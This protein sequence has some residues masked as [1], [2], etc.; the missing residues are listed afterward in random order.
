[1][2]IETKPPALYSYDA[3]VEDR[4]QRIMKANDSRSL[5]QGI[6]W[7]GKYR[8]TKTT[9]RPPEEAF[10]DHMERLLNPSVNEPIDPTLANTT[11]T[12]IPLLDDPFEPEELLKVVDN[13]V[14]PD[15]GCG[16]DGNSPGTLKLLPIAWLSLLLLIMNNIFLSGM[17]PASWA[18]SKLIMIFKK[19]AVM[20]C[21]NYRGISIIVCAAKCYDYLLN[22]RLIQWY[23]PCRE[24]AGAQER[25]GCIEHI[26]S[27]RL[28]IERCMRLR[29]PL[30]IAFIDFSKAYDRVPR[31]YL[32]N[33]L[34]RLGCGKVML[35][36]LIAM[37]SVTKF[38]LGT[39]LIAAALGVKQ[40]SPTSC[41]LFILYVDELIKTIKKTHVTDGFLGWLQLLMLM[42]DTIIIATSHD[43]LR[44]KLETMIEWCNKSG[45]VIN[46]DKTEFMAFNAPPEGKRPI[47]LKTH[48]GIVNVT[49]CSQ[50]TYLGSIFTSDGKVSSAIDKHADTRINAL[51]KLVRFLD[52]NE[53]APFLVKK[54]VVDACF[55][56]SLLYGCESWLGIKPSRRIKTMY[57]K[58]IRMLLGVRQQ[59]SEDVCLIE[60]GYP[61]LEALVRSRQQS[62]IKKQLQE[63]DGMLDDPLM[64]A[65]SITH[66]DNPVLS[67]YIKSLLDGPDDIIQADLQQRKERMR[68]SGKTKIQTYCAINP[69][70]SV[71][72]MYKNPVG[73]R[74]YLRISFTRFRTSSHS[75]K[76]E[77][78][79]WSRIPRDQRT[80]VCN[81]GVQ[82][83]EHVLTACPSVNDIKLKYHLNIANFVEFMN[84]ERSK[85]DLCAVHE[86]M[87]RLES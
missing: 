37:Y 4:W 21:G 79:R 43:K 50:Y 2:E 17:Y 54:C 28:I 16:H 62:F 6:D 23:V 77:T 39:T 31:S 3:K 66:R 26:V 5:W 47:R 14:K 63:R 25:R 7:N 45:M 40:G 75:L 61:S 42:D 67:R 85:G 29:C 57:M 76:I 72:P 30:Y 64:H 19:G 52:I 83:E 34:K 78:G 84:S 35:S 44:L 20:A 53:S 55:A 60:S 36:A 24:Q 56:S 51:N 74:D 18:I 80:C 46:E 13:Q 41:F 9:E 48:V 12:T 27:L 82:T 73:E 33:L 58:A 69:E 1:M 22:N 65:L 70:L 15:K 81:E 11:E 10:R 86:I 68:A 32:M 8:E 59:I 87:K 38:I 71:H 49:H